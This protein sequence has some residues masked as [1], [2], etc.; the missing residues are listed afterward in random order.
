MSDIASRRGARPCFAR[1]DRDTAD[2]RRRSRHRSCSYQT[3]T[4]DALVNTYSECG[5]CRMENRSATPCGRS[6]GKTADRRGTTTRV[7]PRT[8]GGRGCSRRRRTTAGFGI[9]MSGSEEFRWHFGPMFYRGRLGDHQ[10]KVLI[11]GQEGAQDESLSHRSFTGGTGARMQ[12][13]LAPPRD[14]SLVP[15]PEHV[16]VSDLRAVQRPAADRSPS[17]P[18]RRSPSTGTKMFDYVVVRNDLQLV[19]RGR[20]GCEGIAGELGE[21]PRRH[22]RSRQPPPRRRI[23][24]LAAAC[25]WSASCIPVVPAQGGAVAAIIASFK[26][27]INRGPPVGRRRSRVAPGRHRRDVQQRPRRTPTRPTRSRSVTSRTARRVAAR[28]R[29]RPRRIVATA[30]RRHPDLLRGRQVQQRR[31]AP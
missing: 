5:R 19:D 3:T 21:S 23:G 27:A 22:R 4:L 11:V 15:L 18:R 9:A 7:R 20:S 28:P 10:V 8:A 31:R 6:I 14:Q 24:D 12:H 1:W 25:R 2:R 16:R 26:A 17:I 30:R 13:L 29:R